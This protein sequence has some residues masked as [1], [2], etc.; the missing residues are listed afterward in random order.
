MS[1]MED[2]A[3]LAGVRVLEMGRLIA[4]P[5]CGQILSD[6]GAEV[7]KVERIGAG[8]DVRGYGPPFL[9]GDSRPGGTSANFLAFNRNKRS[10]AVDF[11]RPEG[12]DLLREL[13]STCDVFIENYKVG[14][15]ERFGLDEASLRKVKPDIIYVSVSGFGQAGP[16]AA[17]PATDLAIQGLCG[18][19]S[20]TGEPHREPQKVGLQ[21][22]DMM[23]GLY[24]AIGAVASLYKSR[25]RGG[26]G[27]WVGTSLLDCAMAI[28]APAA[29]WNFMDGKPPLRNGNEG[30]G[31]S[32]QGVF[33]CLDG[34]LLIQAGKDRDF[35]KLCR[36][37][38]VEPLVTDPRFAT[39]PLRVVNAEALKDLL[40][41]VTRRWRRDDLYAALVNVGIICGPVNNVA[42][43]MQDPQIVAN[44][45]VQPGLHPDDPELKIVGSPLRFSTGAPKVTRPAPRVGEHTEEVLGELLNMDAAAVAALARSGAVGL[46]GRE[47]PPQ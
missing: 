41:V 2:A 43:A 28:M 10:I 32:P 37:L 30:L 5:L 17:R 16:Y 35:V 19:M 46:Y 22:V 3:P 14:S 39:R 7:I 9:L 15:L 18:L 26:G 20:M 38:E 23:T 31:T 24:A 42:E 40:N 27:E 13:A 45:M 47:A 44:G 4:A 29:I 8:D 12:A 1:H 33:A 36:V 34:E 25:V 6:L 21:V 11:S